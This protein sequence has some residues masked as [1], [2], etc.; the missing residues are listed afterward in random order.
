MLIAVDCSLAELDAVHLSDAA[1]A[2]RC[3]V[4]MRWPLER[5]A[6][7]WLGARVLILTFEPMCES[8]VGID[9]FCECRS[10]CPTLI[11]ELVSQSNS[12]YASELHVRDATG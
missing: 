9:C 7:V 8:R 10:L 3:A 4:I 2:C 11:S 5:R 12:L 6:H 1:T